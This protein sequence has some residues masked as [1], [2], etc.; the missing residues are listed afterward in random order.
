MALTTARLQLDPLA[1][2]DLEPFAE[3]HAST[4]VTRYLSPARPLSH[5][6]SFRLF[7]QVLGHAQ[8]RGFGY[9]AVRLRSDAR[10]LGVVGLWFPEGWPGVELGWR[11][12]P[13]FWGHGYA[14]EASGAV[15]DFAHRELHQRELLSIIHCENLRSLRL[16]D[17]LG[18]SPW[19]QL[20]MAGVPVSVL[21]WTAPQDVE[22]SGPSAP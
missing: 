12:A 9:W 10:W 2:L 7:C 17:K 6:E 18:M 3:L 11:F 20:D 4:E 22:R 1:P 13:D 19:K 5:S 15:L 16:A 8:V 14:E 21:R